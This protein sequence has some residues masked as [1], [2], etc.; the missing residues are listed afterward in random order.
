MNPSYF[1]FLSLFITNY[2]TKSTCKTWPSAVLSTQKIPAVWKHQL[3]HHCIQN[4][5]TRLLIC[6]PGKNKRGE[7]FFCLFFPAVS[8][9]GEKKKKKYRESIK[10]TAG[11]QVSEAI[12]ATAKEGVQE[13]KKEAEEAITRKY[14]RGTGVNERQRRRRKNTWDDKDRKRERRSGGTSNDPGKRQ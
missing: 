5:R 1:P 12:N 4:Q 3:D 6:W 7:V 8:E 11:F 14:H 10:G 13:A 2:F 9:I